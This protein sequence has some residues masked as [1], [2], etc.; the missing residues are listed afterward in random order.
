MNDEENINIWTFESSMGIRRRLD[1]ILVDKRIKIH[2]AEATN[3]INMGSDHRAVKANIE[4]RMQKKKSRPHRKRTKN[5]KPIL[6]MEKHPTIYHE[7]LN[8]Q[9]HKHS[10]TTYSDLESI[11]IDAAE[12]GG[13]PKEFQIIE[14]KP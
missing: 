3:E 2:A 11:I 8:S 6:D 4:I 13:K 5:W 9:L 1:Y 10:I 14:I 7:E 12:K